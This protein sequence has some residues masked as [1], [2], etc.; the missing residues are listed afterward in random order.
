MSN[1]ENA[2]ERP[3]GTGLDFVRD[4]VRADNEAGHLR[5]PRADPVPTGAQRLPAHRPRQGDLRRLRHRRGVRRRLQPAL[6]RHQPRHR[7]H[8]VRRRRSS[9]T[10][11]ARLPAGRARSTRPTTSS[12]STTGP[13]TSSTQGSRLRRRSGRRDDLG[14][15]RRLRQARRR[16]PVPRPSDRREPRPVPPDAR[17]RVP[18]RLARAP[19]QDRHAAREHA[20]ARP[21]DVPHPPRSSLP[22]RATTG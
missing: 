5:R 11:L 6:R 21:G 19:R 12:S 10:S 1:T 7:G 2:I 14:A 22:H 17:R 16:E 15:A 13:S 20:A 9:T 3:C 8:R 4:L 18:R